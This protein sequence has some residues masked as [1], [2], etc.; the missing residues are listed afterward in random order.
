MTILSVVTVCL[1]SVTRIGGCIDSVN[2][3]S[4]P[5]VEHVFVDGGSDDGTVALI[6]SRA[7]RS[8]SI[9]SGRDGGIFDAMNKGVDMATGDV[10]SFLN[11][12]DRYADEDVLAAVA[13][14]FDERDVDF[15]FG[16][17]AMVDNQG[18]VRRAW[19]TRHIEPG[20]LHGEQIPHPALFVR[21]SVLKSLVPCFDSGYRIAGDLKQQLILVNKL[22]CKG[23]RLDRLVTVMSL[24]G[25]STRSLGAYLNGWSESVR[26]YNEVMGSG[27]LIYTL[28]KVARKVPG[29]RGLGAR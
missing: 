26:A 12:D 8:I 19:R 14:S 16:D 6:Q 28:R 9:S 18:R 22:R 2:A 17:I 25:A 4:H 1:N 27:G 23:T 20:S 24:G 29:I 11:S 5:D 3:Q 7:R 10:V 21:A 15:V 13:A